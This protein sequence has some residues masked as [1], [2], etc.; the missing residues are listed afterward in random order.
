VGWVRYALRL[1]DAS[2]AESEPLFPSPSHRT[3]VG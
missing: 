3:S 2:A 1:L